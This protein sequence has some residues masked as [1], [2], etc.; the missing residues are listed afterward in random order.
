[1]L[2]LDLLFSSS[3]ERHPRPGKRQREDDDEEA[4]EDLNESNY[5]EVTPSLY[6]LSSCVTPSLC[7]LC[8]PL[9]LFSFLLGSLVCYPHLTFFLLITLSQLYAS[10]MV[11]QDVNMLPPN[12]CAAIVSKLQDMVLLRQLDILGGIAHKNGQLE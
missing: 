3:D 4:E 7:N 12:H 5:D 8:N 11:L 10:Y 9:V 2:L 1:M 6:D